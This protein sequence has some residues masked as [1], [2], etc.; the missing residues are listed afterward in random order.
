[1]EI[2]ISIITD[3]CYAFHELAAICSV[4]I[5]APRWETFSGEMLAKNASKNSRTSTFEW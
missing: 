2:I 4:G 1:M 5:W 3:A